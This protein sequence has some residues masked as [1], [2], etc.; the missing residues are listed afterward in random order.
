M[1]P[2]ERR[3]RWLLRLLPVDHRAARG[4]ELLGL[5]L[6]LDGRRRWPSLRQAAGVLALA[7]RLRLAGAA[8]MLLTAF[9]I[10]VG[11][12]MTAIVYDVL[13]GGATIAAGWP[14]LVAGL[15]LPMMVRLGAAVA[16]ILGARRTALALVVALIAVE[17]IVT[18]SPIVLDLALVVVLAA[19]V[20]WRWPAPRR[21]MAAL[22]AVP[23]AILLWVLGA[24]WDHHQRLSWVP[25]GA[26]AVV[27]ALIAG[28]LTRRLI[29]TA[30][31]GCAPVAVAWLLNQRSPLLAVTLAVAL[32]AVM[33]GGRAAARLPGSPAASDPAPPG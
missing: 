15:F 20:L 9:V 31:A 25:V 32:V 27:C 30:A 1:S 17:T 7:T 2:L 10:A 19:A 14:V 29:V 16:W 13:I 3:Y 33:L 8:A 22:A 24:A 18:G 5:L 21:R 6:D 12:S 26:A 11:T 23:L 28:V 4:E